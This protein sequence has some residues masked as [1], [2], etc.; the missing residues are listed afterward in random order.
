[1]DYSKLNNIAASIQDVENTASIVE[2]RLNTKIDEDIQSLQDAISDI[3]NNPSESIDSNVISAALNDLNDKTDNLTKD[4]ESLERVT[5][6]SLNDLN[7]KVEEQEK[8]TSSSLVD[9]SE[10]V[11][12]LTD[13]VNDNERVVSTSLNDLNEKVDD[14]NDKVDNNELITASALTDLNDKSVQ[15]DKDGN[16]I[17]Q[18]KNE[19]DINDTKHINKKI[20]IRFIDDID[21]FV[22]KYMKIM[23]AVYKEEIT[24]E[25]ENRYKQSVYAEQEDFK[26]F[27]IDNKEYQNLIINKVYDS[28][29]NL[30]DE[31]S[32]TEAP[33]LGIFSKE[34]PIVANTDY[35]VNDFYVINES[36]TNIFDLKKSGALYLF[37]VGNYSG[38]SNSNDNSN[39]NSNEESENPKS[40]QEVISNL[41]NNFSNLESN[42][43]NLDF[44]NNLKIDNQGNLVVHE[45]GTY[46]K[47][48]RGSSGFHLS[49]DYEKIY[50]AL[51][52]DPD[53]PTT[54]QTDA[55]TQEELKQLLV[56]DDLINPDY[57]YYIVLEED[58]G[59]GYLTN[60]EFFSPDNSEGFRK[61]ISV[62][63]NDTDVEFSD[64][65]EKFNDDDTL[66]YIVI[67]LETEFSG[68]LSNVIMDYECYPEFDKYIAKLNLYNGDLYLPGIGNYTPKNPSYNVSSVQQVLN[69][70]SITI[71]GVVNIAIEKSG[72]H[73]DDNDNFISYIPNGSNTAYTPNT[74]KNTG[75]AI[76]IGKS[77]NLIQG[78]NSVVIGSGNYNVKDYNVT[79]GMQNR[80]ESFYGI[81]IGYYNYNASVINDNISIGRNNQIFKDMDG[82]VI[83]SY[84]NVARFTTTQNGQKTIAI[85]KGLF[86]DND[87]I[88]LGFYNAYYNDGEVM[89][90]FAIANGIADNSRSNILEQYDNG[91]LF[92]KGLGGFTGANSQYNRNTPV[93]CKTLQ[94]II[95]DLTNRIASL[96]TQISGGGNS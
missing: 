40:V 2:N 63:I 87:N 72:L 88:T 52:Y 26:L 35:Y 59:S 23:K 8:I 9:L 54:T 60:S 62:E 49:N 41:E 15:K 67:G 53:S 95:T 30:I 32:I 4:V 11:D 48:T 94:Q 66:A 89:P 91:D 82:I 17:I 10:K 3:G 70:F 24:P 18:K 96:E 79:V 12:E 22:S 73:Y 25:A 50:T 44:K 14:L 39:D 5:S 57:Y 33:G 75:G 7:V 77:N 29:D 85:G 34:S 65:I 46:E 37:G 76:I 21:S 71:P 55:Y 78:N 69:S 61:F 90:K 43:Q 64:Y 80:N 13:E 38:E 58:G 83:G 92:I 45:I 51:T 36:F 42:L 93:E 20:K 56:E 68:N 6:S 19:F 1:M 28:N 47:E 86:A 81:N 27:V 74:I 16:V 31:Q 84:N